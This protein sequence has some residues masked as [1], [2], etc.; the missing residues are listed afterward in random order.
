MKPE[1]L[2]D[3]LLE[4]D[5]EE[6]I[7]GVTPP[8]LIKRTLAAAKLRNGASQA[9]DAT[10]P[11][12][13]LPKKRNELWGVSAA[14][15]CFVIGMG[16]LVLS[17]GNGEDDTEVNN[18]AEAE[19]TLP[20]TIFASGDTKYE[21]R[22][23]R[24][25]LLSGWMLLSDG[26]PDIRVGDGRVDGIRG[27]ALIMEGDTLPTLNQLRN[28]KSQLIKENLILEEESEMLNKWVIRSSMCVC[29][30]AGGLMVNDSYVS[31]AAPD[32]VLIGEEGEKKEKEEHAKK[33]KAEEEAH[34]SEENAEKRAHEK[35]MRKKRKEAGKKE[36]KKEGGGDREREREEG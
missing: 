17:P 26:A 34:R 9:E 27:N 6:A 16:L 7:G 31:A 24:V 14:A 11:L 15:A 8:D 4:A 18:T 22:D 28:M 5:L 19:K 12:K 2:E 13:S 35:A 25:N 10:P 36:K 3:K 23:G 20:Q 32:M 33:K 29:V 21:L 1:T 30:L